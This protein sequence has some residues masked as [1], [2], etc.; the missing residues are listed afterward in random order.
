MYKPLK[1]ATQ[2]FTKQ[3]EYW[4]HH[5]VKQC[6]QGRSSL[7]RQ[8]LYR[9]V[10]HELGWWWSRLSCSVPPAD[11]QHLQTWACWT[12]SQ[13]LILQITQTEGSDK[14]LQPIWRQMSCGCSPKPC[15]TAFQSIYQCLLCN[16][17]QSSVQLKSA[18]IVC[19]KQGWR[20]NDKMT[21]PWQH[22]ECLLNCLT[23]F[24]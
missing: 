22:V 14:I 13:I 19:Y 3:K 17:K 11:C 9:W 16:S 18:K 20:Q 4:I 1:N 6:S 23:Y 8:I 15:G 24:I 2:K 12:W 7:H 5:T 21:K 10:C